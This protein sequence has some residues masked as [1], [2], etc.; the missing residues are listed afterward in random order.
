MGRQKSNARKLKAAKVAG[1]YLLFGCLWILFSDRLL[2]SALSRM[3]REGLYADFQTGKGWFFILVTSAGLYAALS[4]YQQVLNDRE[5]ALRRNRDQYRLVVDGANDGLWD[6]EAETGRLTFPR[7]KALLGYG[8][9]EVADSLE[10][11]RS[12]IHPD[13]L[14]VLDDSLGLYL[15]KPLGIWETQFRMIGKDGSS[16]FILARGAA[17]LDGT[18]RLIR[19]SGSHT[20]IT[21]VKRNEEKILQIAYYD[22]LTGLP[23]KSLFN[24]R[25]F[26]RIDRPEPNKG[27]SLIY[28]DLDDFKAVNDSA[29]HDIGD[30]LLVE[31][32]SFLKETV[33][34]P[35]FLGRLGGDEFG[36]ILPG[37]SAAEDLVWAETLLKRF[38]EP[39]RVRGR[40]YRLT[41]SM[42]LA[43]YPL[44]GTDP[45]TLMK[46]ADIAMYRAKTT[47][48][49][50][51][52][53]FTG[54]MA[55]EIVR[56]VEMEE[57][58]REAV[59]GEAFRVLYQPKFRVRGR[60]LV[61][62]E[63]LVRWDHPKFGLILPG[64]FIPV[65][66]ETG[67]ILSIGRQVMA[68]AL[69]VQQRIEAAVRRPIDISVNVS[70]VQFMHPEFTEELKT[71]LDAQ[72]TSLGRLELEITESLLMQNH[73]HIA[74]QLDRLRSWGVR[75]S[76]DDFG[77]GYSALGYLHE[78]NLD[79]LKIDKSFLDEICSSERERHIVK[80]IVEMAHA[81]KL[82]VVAEGIERPKQ[83]EIL[84]GMG[85]DQMQGFLLGVPMEEASV[86][87]FMKRERM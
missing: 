70:V 72:P 67:L 65:A 79:T 51:C 27:F 56:R 42:G 41:A 2:M 61:G 82:D 13:D 1:I 25:L 76:L 80:A 71:M 54:E 31:I 55:E 6:W 35:M 73:R 24:N 44:D 37:D 60:E 69:A 7:T 84:E 34:P 46:H 86:L 77:K 18:G 48:R 19:M 28:M 16:F 36:F 17:R 40:Q 26:S 85:C 39:W 29:G 62:F 74:D 83:I 21:R 33:G 10:G 43:R 8:P 12:L 59:A 81:L 22:E 4:R 58:L 3:G 50:Q 57:E 75:V 30:M 20:D 53:R 5:T 68:S 47:G 15:E 52:L 63:A 66:E 14:S 49:N 9:Q 64:R 32:A 45:G 78:F 87:E 11:F 23:N 38:E